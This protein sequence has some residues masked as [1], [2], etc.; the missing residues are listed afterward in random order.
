MT[1]AVVVILPVPVHELWD[2]E[3]RFGSV[4]LDFLLSTNLAHETSMS[5]FEMQGCDL[6][7]S[8]QRD[9]PAW[10][11]SWFG[12]AGTNA[13]ARLMEPRFE[14]NNQQHLTVTADIQDREIDKAGL[15]NCVALI[16]RKFPSLFS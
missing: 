4:Y 5:Y 7:W 12:I 13:L 16:R 11:A 2:V 9:F 10:K 8:L 3:A 15:E 14:A 1:E 6:H